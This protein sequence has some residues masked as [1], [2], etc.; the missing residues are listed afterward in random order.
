MRLSRKVLKTQQVKKDI[1]HREEAVQRHRDTK[2]HVH[3]E[4]WA[5][6]A[7]KGQKEG[8]FKTSLNP[9]EP[10]TAQHRGWISNNRAQD[11]VGP[12]GL[13]GCSPEDRLH[14]STGHIVLSALSRKGKGQL[15]LL[16]WIKKKSETWI[17]SWN[18]LERPS[19]S[20]MYQGPSL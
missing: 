1:S 15:P 3:K 9:G 19:S 2:L 16:P 5:W 11:M 7:R 12:V 17:S 8:K 20:V 14:R 10:H 6:S 13:D 4:Q 18:L